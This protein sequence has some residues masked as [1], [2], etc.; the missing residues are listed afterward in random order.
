MI[1][2][3]FLFLIIVALSSQDYFI[4]KF[5]EADPSHT[6]FDANIR[7]CAVSSGIEFC[8][9]MVIWFVGG[10]E[11]LFHL[12]TVVL[13]AGFGVCFAAATLFSLLAVAEGSLA[14]S[15][16]VISYSL[17]LPTAWSIVFNG[18]E[19]YKSWQFIAG[20]VM[21]CVSLFLIRD[22]DG[23]TVTKKWVLYVVLA[24]V[25]NGACNI[26]MD[27]HQQYYPGQYRSSFLATSMIFVEIISVAVILIRKRKTKAHYNPL[28]LVVCSG[29]NGTSNAMANLLV[30]TVIGAGVIPTA[31]M[32]PVMSA[33]QFTFC[34]LMSFIIFHE[35]FSKTQYI[36][37]FLGAAS[38]VLLN[39]A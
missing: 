26:L 35:R 6:S 8:V 28:A 31:I 20:I 15:T 10:C 4:K 22:K 37:Y 27:V 29:M 13:S 21:L 3:L 36:G 30:M 39:M 16:L 1:Q 34:F 14:L 2:Y 25:S 11:D 12:P 19:Q 18:G 32:F 17:L 9:L 24:F 23:K 5:K 38:V 33:G 7:F